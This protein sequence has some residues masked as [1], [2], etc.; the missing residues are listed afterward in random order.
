VPIGVIHPALTVTKTA[1]PDIVR[2]GE[3]VTY[4]MVVANTGDVPLTNVTMADSQAPGCALVFALI[5]PG[6]LRTSVC[7][8]TAGDATFV[9]TV[10]VS[11]TP[12]VGPA[13]TDSA[14]TTVTVIHPSL[15][16]SKVGSPSVAPGRRPRLVHDHGAEY[17]RHHADRRHPRRRPV[18]IL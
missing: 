16:V 18:P 13:V 11:G 5:E 15:A 2:P 14:A 1:S 6:D 10:T 12:P 7:T 3:L 4:T 17:R 8:V 9:N